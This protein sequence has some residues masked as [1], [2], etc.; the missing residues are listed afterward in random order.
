SD[1]GIAKAVSEGAGPARGA[2]LTGVG[3]VLGT[4]HFMA[5][6]LIMGQPFDGRVDQYALAVTVYELL[7]GRYPFDGPN[8]AAIFVAHTTQEVPALIQVRPDVTPALSAAAAR[9]MA[10]DPGRRF[11]SCTAFARAVLDAVATP[12]MALPD[13]A[14]T[15]VAE[16]MV[17]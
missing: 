4:P 17:P 1:F 13:V 10:K 12:A 3:M 11:A 8:A 6:E 16:E 2:T 14:G 15:P 5:P 9:A 7:A